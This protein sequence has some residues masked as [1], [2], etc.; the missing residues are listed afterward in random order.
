MEMYEEL[1]KY[2]IP[3]VR[4]SA[5]EWQKDYAVTYN[6]LGLDVPEEDARFA[7]EDI[8]MIYLLKK[9]KEDNDG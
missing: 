4:I 1:R 8:I 2:G 7:A 6:V 5:E 3:Q 9:A